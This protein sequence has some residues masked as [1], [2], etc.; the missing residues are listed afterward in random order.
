MAAC[1]CVTKLDCTFCVVVL[2]CSFVLWFYVAILC[3]GFGW[4]LGFAFVLFVL[5]F[6]FDLSVFIALL[7]VLYFVF[8]P[9]ALGLSFDYSSPS[10]DDCL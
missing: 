6:A 2:Y 7:F 9:A 4:L 3:C 10:I 1:L 8:I 5:C